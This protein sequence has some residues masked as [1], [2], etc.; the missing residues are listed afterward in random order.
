M[1]RRTD[2]HSSEASKIGVVGAGYVGLTTAA[3]LAHLGHRV[4][5]ADLDE[6]R[7]AGL[8]RGE[9]PIV[10][11]GLAE[12]VAS[13]L[14]N[15]RLTFE[16]GAAAR[17]RGRRRR[18]PLRA[19]AAGPDGGADLRYIEA[20]AAEIAPALRPGALVVNKSTVPVGSTRAVED[21]LHRPDVAVV[22]NPEFL[23]EGTAV[24]DF[25]QPRPGRHRRRR[26][27]RR[28]AARR[29]LRRRSTPPC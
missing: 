1:T 9:I 19:D 14:A 20:A 3:C 8:R 27:R 2:N 10:E 4:V 28:R 26:P 11:E 12:I 24:A 18:V 16:V 7:V 17:G 29:G 13:T 23:R 25:L 6:D 22:S 5:C 15:G 21:V